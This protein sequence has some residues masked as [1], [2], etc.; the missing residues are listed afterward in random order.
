MRSAQF[1]L[2]KRGCSVIHGGLHD[3]IEC[4]CLLEDYA[5]RKLLREK[6]KQRVA[7]CSRGDGLFNCKS[8]KE[9]LSFSS[10]EENNE[11]QKKEGA[12]ALQKEGATIRAL[13]LQSNPL[14]LYTGVKKGP[15][16]GK[17]TIGSWSYGVQHLFGAMVV[18]SQQ[19]PRGLAAQSNRGR[20]NPPT[21]A[22]R[23]SE[24]SVLLH[25]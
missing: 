10:K 1:Y 23:C 12:I 16:S 21:N 9:L 6:V 25:G 2:E 3:D 17:A 4:Y 20:V 15:V 14:P 7:P 5:R 22:S 24:K 8:G 19:K 18:S 11:H 13:P